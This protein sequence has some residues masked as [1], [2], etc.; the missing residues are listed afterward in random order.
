MVAKLKAGKNF[1]SFSFLFSFE[2]YFSFLSFYTS[3]SSRGSAIC[4]IEIVC[5]L[6]LQGG[7]DKVYKP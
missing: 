3:S 6:M 4:F 2:F 5:I 1:N 7:L